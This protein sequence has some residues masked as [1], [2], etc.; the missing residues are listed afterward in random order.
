MEQ[1]DDPAEPHQDPPRLED[2]PLYAN[3]EQVCYH[4]PNYCHIINYPN[5]L[6]CKQGV[7]TDFY[8]GG[9]GSGGALS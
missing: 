5:F 4:G 6:P 8:I 1:Q 7:L 9:S 2:Q 3:V